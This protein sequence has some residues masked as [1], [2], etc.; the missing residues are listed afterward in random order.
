MKI[1][2]T[3]SINAMDRARQVLLQPA[4]AQT[5]A[6]PVANTDELRAAPGTIPDETRWPRITMV[7]PVY[8]GVRYIE[9]TICSIV[10]QGYPNLEYIVVDGGSTDGTVDVIRKYGKHISWWVS[11]RDKGVYDALNNGFSH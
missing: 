11:R 5:L 6:I 10:H 4:S 1:I 9:E 2:E 7:T 8:N 3:V